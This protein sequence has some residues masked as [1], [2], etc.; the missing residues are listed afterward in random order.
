M[1]VRQSWIQLDRWERGNRQPEVH[2]CRTIC[3]ASRWRPIFGNGGR[4]WCLPSTCS[5]HVSCMWCIWQLRRQGFAHL[6][7]LCAWP[8]FSSSIRWHGRSELQGHGLLLCIV[9]D[10]GGGWRITSAAVYSYAQHCSVRHWVVGLSTSFG[11][12]II[13]IWAYNSQLQGPSGACIELDLN[14]QI[15]H[16]HV[17]TYWL[18]ITNSCSILLNLMHDRVYAECHLKLENIL[19]YMW[20]PY[21]LYTW[22]IKLCS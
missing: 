7:L 17:Q 22:T 9:Y 3:K 15:P 16:V 14:N 8:L 13:L 11:P 6:P 21:R 1:A 18:W 12:P 10:D 19:D 5:P 4:A 20:V 2:L